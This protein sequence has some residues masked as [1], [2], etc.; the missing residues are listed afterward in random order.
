MNKRRLKHEKSECGTEKRL[1]PLFLNEP[2]LVPAAEIVSIH[3][4]V[5]ELC[6][7]LDVIPHRCSIDIEQI[8]FVSMSAPLLCRHENDGLKL[9][10]PYTWASTLIR[11]SSSTKLLVNVYDGKRS[12]AY[13]QALA[14][15]LFVI[16]YLQ[17]LDR[18][19]TRIRRDRVTQLLFSDR[20][21]ELFPGLVQN[22][23]VDRNV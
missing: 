15:H 2:M 4:D 18:T 16:P 5:I 1:K 7:E 9:L 6:N 21:R 17:T 19:P 13:W 8:A 12:H 23:G 20:Y 14:S 10:A 11:S 22:V 3:S